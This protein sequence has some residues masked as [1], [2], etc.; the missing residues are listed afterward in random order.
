MKL[1]ALTITS[2]ASIGEPGLT[3]PIDDIVVLIGPNNSGKSSILNA[4]EAFASTGS[5]LSL[6]SFRDED[7][8]STI[9]ISGVFTDLTDDDKDIIGGKWEYD[10]PEFGRAVKA[11]WEWSAAEWG[12]GTRLSPAGSPFRYAY[13]QPTIPKKRRSRLSRS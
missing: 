4:Y 10:D 7:A 11:K 2:F 12:A 5:P 3:I 6:R 9:S 8:S 1:R 13:V